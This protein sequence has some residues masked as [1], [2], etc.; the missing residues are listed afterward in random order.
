MISHPNAASEPSSIIVPS[1]ARNV[2]VVSKLWPNLDLSLQ[3]PNAGTEVFVIMT[4][5]QE[6]QANRSGE[7]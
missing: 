1:A 6:D 7:V 3:P 2:H 5:I 4:A